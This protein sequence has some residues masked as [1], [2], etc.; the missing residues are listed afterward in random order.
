MSNKGFIEKGNKIKY[1]AMPSFDETKLVKHSFTT[2]IGGHSEDDFHA[3]NLGRKTKDFEENVCNNYNS[4]FEELGLDINK[5]VVSDQIHS[6]NVHII[7]AGDEVIGNI[8]ENTLKDVDALITDVKD[9]VLV[10]YYADCTPL[11][12]LDTKNKVI[13]LAH[14]GWKGTVSKIGLKVVQKMVEC[15]GSDA[16]DIIAG[17][18]PCI[19]SCCYEVDD[20]VIN[21]FRNSFNGDSYYKFKHDDK[22]DLDLT[23][24]NKLVLLEAGLSENNINVANLCTHC[25]ERYFYSYRRDKGSTGRMCAIMSLI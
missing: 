22:Y 25:Q 13:A 6:D 21:R 12:F 15:F 3:L 18:G 2:R 5:I 7:R 11:Y 8:K 24:A 1:F 20:P 23:E 4:I 19:G 17:I 10:T 14:S 9:I 16:K